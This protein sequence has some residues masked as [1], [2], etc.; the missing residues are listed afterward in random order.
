[1]YFHDIIKFETDTP[2]YGWAMNTNRRQIAA[3]GKNRTLAIRVNL[4]NKVES[5][6]SYFHHLP[7]SGDLSKI[8]FISAKLEDD[9]FAICFEKKYFFSWSDTNRTRFVEH[10]KPITSFV[11]LGDCYVTAS[12][13]GTIQR[14]N[15]MRE[16][17]LAKSNFHAGLRSDMLYQAQD[18]L[19]IVICDSGEV[20]LFDGTNLGDPLFRWFPQ[21][22]MPYNSKVVSILMKGT[23]LVTASNNGI[24]NVWDTSRSKWSKG[25]IE[26]VMSILVNN[27]TAMC[28]AV[29]DEYLVFATGEGLIRIHDTET[30]EFV[31]SSTLLGHV[32]DQI[33]S[34]RHERAL[35]YCSK[36]LLGNKFNLIWS[37]RG[38][39]YYSRVHSRQWD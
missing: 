4:E 7:E 29:E 26:P 5:V 36:Y 17:T 11:S 27:V 15:K 16:N 33:A 3:I 31:V 12:Q 23:L 1:M 8:G 34:F 35:H 22:E 32:P 14:W 18:N 38:Q 37:S 19:I 21:G 9:F 10:E 28:T 6:R 2:I 25:F 39:L 24:V 20:V 30:G 13:N